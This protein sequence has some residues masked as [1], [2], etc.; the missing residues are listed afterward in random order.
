MK[1]FLAGILLIGLFTGGLSTISLI[2]EYADTA[3]A[4]Y[5]K[6]DY[7]ESIAAYEYLLE[8]LEVQDDQ[9]RLNLG[10]SYFRIGELQKARQQYTLLAEHSSR[11]IRA[12]ALLQLGNI[13]AQNKKYMQALSYFRNALVVEPGNALARYN[14]ELIKKFL[15]LRP[16]L[17]EEDDTVTDTTRQAGQQ[18]NQQQPDGLQPPPPSDNEQTPQPKKKPDSTG[19]QEDEVESQQEDTQGQKEENAPGNENNLSDKGTGNRPENQEKQEI[20]GREPGDTKG[21]NPDSNFDPARPERS[22]SSDPATEAE[23]RAQT[24]NSRL[25]QM[26]INPE[27][28]RLMLDAMRSA[29]QQYIQQLPK[30]ATR[31]PDSS[32][33]NW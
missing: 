3:A 33:P 4:A 18:Q 2:N 32:K 8:N 11:H 16:E 25:Q 7:I 22:R 29:E 1:S 19:D 28:A 26:N 10:H 13:A 23:Q 14:Y 17:A 15:E 21:I 9:L 20:S 24:R 30:K 27:K 5:K 6:G 12:I 31:K